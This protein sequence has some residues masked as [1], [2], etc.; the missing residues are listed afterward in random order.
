L[1]HG[2][3]FTPLKSVAAKINPTRFGVSSTESSDKA[4]LSGLARVVIENELYKN[5]KDIEILKLFLEYINKREDKDANADLFMKFYEQINKD[6]KPEMKLLP[7]G[8]E[9]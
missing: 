5:A 4:S 3:I 6:K 1:G 9:Q 7:N 2:N 8:T